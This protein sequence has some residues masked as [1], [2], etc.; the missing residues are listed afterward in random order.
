[1]GI[2]ARPR[3]GLH[4]RRIWFIAPAAGLVVIGAVFG[5]G[6]GLGWFRGPSSPTPAASPHVVVSP[7]AAASPTPSPVVSPT[8]PSVLAQLHGKIAISNGQPGSGGWITFPGGGFTADPGSNVML[9]SGAWPP[10]LTHDLALNRWV[11]APRDWVTPDGSKYVYNFG[12]D[13]HLVTPGSSDRVL[14]MPS[15]QTV[16]YWSILAATNGSVYVSPNGYPQIAGLYRI[17]FSG[18]PVRVADSGYWNYVDGTYAYGSTTAALPQGAAN[19]IV[20]LNLA[21]GARSDLFTQPGMNSTVAGVD[22]DGDAVVYAID[23]SAH[24]TL[25]QIWIARPGA[26]LKIYEKM[27][28]DTAGGMGGG[29]RFNVTSVVADSMGTWI[30]TSDGLYLY[31]HQSGLEFASQVT[32]PLA[33]AFRKS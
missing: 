15:P 13:V 30:A 32:G 21:T 26:P 12:Y 23:S 25:A 28:S 22:S 18:A 6:F 4:V 11:P 29:R 2:A 33:S 3:P 24:P 27:I 31:S 5:L 17:P 14:P 19:T 10:G 8:P 7:S 20:R 9:P 1:M 16:S